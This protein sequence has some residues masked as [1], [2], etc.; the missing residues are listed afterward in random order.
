MP[1]YEYIASSDL[2]CGHCKAGFE[3]LQPLDS[4]RLTACPE[5]GNPVTRRISAPN[6]G[7]TGQDALKQKNLEQ[8]GFTQYRKSAKGVYEKTAGKGPDMI[9][10]DGK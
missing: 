4:P 8:H 9:M 7:A 2:T 3:T 5:C 1:I 10:D 6:I